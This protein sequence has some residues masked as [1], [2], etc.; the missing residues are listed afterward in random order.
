MRIEKLGLWTIKTYSRP[1]DPCKVGR[2]RRIGQRGPFGNEVHGC[3][4]HTG[5][6]EMFIPNFVTFNRPARSFGGLK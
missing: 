6:A 3:I 5:P 2:R 1:R 4:L